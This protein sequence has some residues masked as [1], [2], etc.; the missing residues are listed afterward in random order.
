[1][2][3]KQ[4]KSISKFLSYVLRHHPE[5]IG[6]TLNQKG[7]ACVEELI[8]KSKENHLLLTKEMIQEVVA[9][10]DK[11]RFSF[12]EDETMIRANQGHSLQYIDLGMESKVPPAILY[13]GTI[14][15]FL[16]SIQQEGLKKG[17][18]QHVHLS[19]DVEIAK[20][21]GGRRGKPI[22]LKVDAQK[23]YE[24]GYTFFLSENGVWLTEHVPVEFIMFNP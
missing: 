3:S 2:D 9:T 24:A 7:W 21:V 4:K 19:I 11:K 13:H 16:E 14:H 10:N 18:R 17:S 15:K 5:L 6:L 8:E 20:D 1:M 12:N 23:M 22:V